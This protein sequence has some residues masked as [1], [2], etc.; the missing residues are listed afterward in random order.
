M[1][2]YDLGQGPDE[3]W[4]VAQEGF[5]EERQGKCESIFYVGNGYMGQRAAFEEA[6]FGQTR[7]LLVA[8]TFDRADDG[9]VTE[10]P[11]LP[12]VTNMEMHINGQRFSMRNGENCLLTLNLK[13]G[14][15]RRTLTW[16]AADGARF[17][18][19]F[20]RFASME[21][22]HLLAQRVTITPLDAP[23]AVRLDSGIDGRVTTTGTQHFREGD[24]RLL[25]GNVLRMTSQ[26]VESGITCC[27]HTVH[28]FRL[29]GKTLEAGQ[30]VKVGRRLL[31]IG[32]AADVPRGSSLTVEK[33]TCVTTTHDQAYIA[34]ADAV[35]RAQAD[36]MAQITQAAGLGYEAL[37]AQS[38]K[39]WAEFWA[40]AD[41]RVE[42]DRPLDQ[43]ALRFALYHLHISASSHDERV[44][45]GAKSLSGEGYK[46]HSFWDTEVF[47][48]PFFTLTAPQT[49]RRL[50]GYRYLGLEGARRKAK[51][52]GY[53]GAMYPWEA[54]RPEDGE[55]TPLFGATD[56]TTGTAMRIL[57]GQIE[58]HITADVAFGVEQYLLATGDEAFRAQCGDEILI[59]TARFWAS[60]AEWDEARD[61]YVIRDVIGP[62]E[63]SEHVDNNAYTNYMAAYDM[64]CALAA[65]ARPQNEPSEETR[66]LDE[67]LG[68]EEARR[69]IERVAAKLYLPKPTEDGLLPQFDGYLEQPYKDLTKYKQS[70]RVASIY[71]DYNLTQISQFQAH[72]QADTVELLVLMPQ[73][74]DA[75]KRR[76]NFEYDEER[77]LHDSSLSK[78]AHCIAAAD[79]GDAELAYRFF[80]GCCDVDIG[81]NMASSDV[82][83]H[84]AS[85]GGIWQAAV[86]GFGGVRIGED[87]LSVRPCL[88]KAW[89]TLSFRLIW[90]GQ[91]LLLTMSGQDVSIANAGGEAVELTLKGQPV[92]IGAGETVRA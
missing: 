84:T 67:K 3:N 1:M 55:V 19:R 68:L 52:N 14:C 35:A 22:E 30:K 72:K 34:Q 42:S 33:L 21:N 2:R 78:S 91:P 4:I 76:K 39:R 48:L 47:V 85:M 37:F 73:L 15:V 20:E 88:P 90:R 41:V 43:L 75:E 53:R 23:A 26:T 79:F 49:A 18:L 25:G 54:A 70:G 8:G 83:I 66:R 50:L 12:D 57:T 10:L 77:T 6:Y 27:L 32:A 9:E 81:E 86:Y 7:D 89:K 63:Y 64:C 58:Q 29:N 71:D 62:D 11:N 45:I 51:E 87:G 82:G 24:R 46:G 59:D 28:L 17:E 92:R 16:T 61:A 5:S 56:V 80:C 65:I 74:L 38:E 13:N 69:E 40:R 44:G 31:T 60:R 36:G